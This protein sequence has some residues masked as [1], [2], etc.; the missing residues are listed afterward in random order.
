MHT[1]YSTASD[2]SAAWRRPISVSSPPLTCRCVANKHLGLVPHNHLSAA[3]ILRRP[4]DC[5]PLFGL[6]NHLAKRIASV[7]RAKEHETAAT[8]EARATIF[9][10]AW[11]AKIRHSASGY[12]PICCAV[13]NS[14][15][16]T[17]TETEM[18][19]VT[20]ISARSCF[21]EG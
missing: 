3:E 18:A 9:R 11:V 7:V 13:L 10:L 2:A 14:S 12:N 21:N 15:T 17:G 8:R 4:P 19:L 16:S 1:G 6:G 5:S 20:G